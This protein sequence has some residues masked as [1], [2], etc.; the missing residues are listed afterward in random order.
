MIGEIHQYHFSSDEEHALI[1]VKVPAEQWAAWRL[2]AGWATPQVGQAV[3]LVEAWRWVISRDGHQMEEI[4]KDANDDDTHAL[5]VVLAPYV[6]MGSDPP[7]AGDLRGRQ[8]V[9]FPRV[10]R[11]GSTDDCSP[12]VGEQASAR[13]RDLRAAVPGYAG[14]GDDTTG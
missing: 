14:G 3:V 1:T 4:G 11:T 6:A 9:G 2:E 8:A 10:H 13:M 5:G 7:V 12:R